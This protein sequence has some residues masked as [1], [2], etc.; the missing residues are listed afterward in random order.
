M[1]KD[2]EFRVRFEAFYGNDHGKRK[3]IYM[4][5]GTENAGL[6]LH[7]IGVSNAGL[8]IVGLLN[9]GNTTSVNR[10][11][12]YLVSVFMSAAWQ[13]ILKLV[14]CGKKAYVVHIETCMLIVEI[15]GM[16]YTRHN[17]IRLVKV[18]LSN[19]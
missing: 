19:K 1:C 7:Y 4:T 13:T 12:I 17:K 16:L 9:T 15:T 11:K 5:D 6:S 2:L 14:F 8:S 10:E 18:V 3:H